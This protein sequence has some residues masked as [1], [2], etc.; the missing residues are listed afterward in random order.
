M[1]A[2]LLSGGTLRREN[3][4]NT[5]VLNQEQNVDVKAH[6]QAYVE[7]HVTAMTPFDENLIDYFNKE[8]FRNCR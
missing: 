6:F 7:Q 3:K 5:R 1:P 2:F 4:E 8:M